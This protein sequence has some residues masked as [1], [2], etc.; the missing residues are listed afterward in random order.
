MSGSSLRAGSAAAAD[1]ELVITIKI[2]VLISDGAVGLV[3]ITGVKPLGLTAG[4]LSRVFVLHG[5]ASGK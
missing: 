4:T 3:R 1:S 5:Q 2:E